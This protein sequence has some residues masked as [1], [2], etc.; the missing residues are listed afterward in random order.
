M[1]FWLGRKVK[2]KVTAGSGDLLVAEPLPDRPAKE[3]Q[4]QAW[5]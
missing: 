4:L 1:G 2:R 3:L 5:G